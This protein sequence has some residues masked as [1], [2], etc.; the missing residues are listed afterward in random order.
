MGIIENNLMTKFNDGHT[1]Q[2][3]HFCLCNMGW[4]YKI[5]I[6]LVNNK[7]QT[8]I[9]VAVSWSIFDADFKIFLNFFLAHHFFEIFLFLKF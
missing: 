5:Q 3:K 6:T 2:K 7:F 4:S 1:N 8:E 9:L